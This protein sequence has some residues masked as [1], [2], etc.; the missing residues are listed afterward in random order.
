MEWTET[1]VVLSTRK[2]GEADV[3]LEVMTAKHGRHLGLVRGGRSR[4]RQPVLQPGNEVYLSWRARLA[5]HLGV[6]AVELAKARAANLMTSAL[7]LHGVQ[8]L[9]SLVRLLPERDAHQSVHNALELLL[10]HLD[11]PAIAAPLLVRFELEMLAE[12]G[13]GLDLAKCAATG[14]TDDLAYVS[15]KSARA[16]SR[17][18][19]LP[20]H[21]KLLPLP[22]FLVNGQRQRGSEISYKD[23]QD[24]FQLTAFFLERNGPTNNASTLDLRSS[25]I[26]AL[27]KSYRT[28][29]PW[30]FFD[31]PP[32]SG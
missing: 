11:D 30:D 13:F 4:R 15:P 19:G 8:H 32:L 31:D 26:A 21:D 17:E 18:A 1:G 3:I 7:G 5:D 25:M 27:E 14:S 12:L 6:F 24:G 28:T 29:Q 10:D 9:A 16:V 20:Y 22:S 2:H 23:I